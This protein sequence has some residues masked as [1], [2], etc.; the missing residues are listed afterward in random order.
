MK[1]LYIICFFV[2]TIFTS[3]A[4]DICGP[5][6]RGQGYEYSPI[7]TMASGLKL[8]FWAVG[9]GC[10]NTEKNINGT[11]GFVSAELVYGMCGADTAENIIVRGQALCIAAKGWVAQSDTDFD[12]R[13]QTQ[14]SY[15]WCRRTNMINTENKLVDSVGQW[16]LIG[17]T[18]QNTET[19][20]A[21]C[22]ELCAKNVATDAVDNNGR[23]SAGNAIMVLSA[24]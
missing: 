3:Y 2:F 15:C 5:A 19:C 12:E 17:N 22:A 20:H 6:V 10:G 7:S 14:G 8:G 23:V 1:Q 13:I 18:Q 24:F 16:V 21:T 4:I 9:P 11:D